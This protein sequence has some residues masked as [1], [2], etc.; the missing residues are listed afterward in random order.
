MMTATAVDRFVETGAPLRMNDCFNPYA[1]RHPPFDIEDASAV[2]ASN[3]RHI[4]SAAAKAGVADL[5]IGLELGQDGERRTGLV[6]TDDAHIKTHD[7]SGLGSFAP[8]DAGWSRQGNDRQ[9]SLG[10]ARPDR[11]TG[12]CET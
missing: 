1:D 10:G 12:F 2:R 6:M 8:R 7:P 11:M 9:H 3:L 5:W 4:L